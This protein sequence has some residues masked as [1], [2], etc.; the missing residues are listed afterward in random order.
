MPITWPHLKSAGSLK[1]SGSGL[2]DGTGGD[3]SLETLTVMRALTAM[4]RTAFF[5]ARRGYL[6]L[7]TYV[8]HG[9]T[10]ST[11]YF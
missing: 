5:M 3:C 11:G 8:N 6:K 7:S 4:A 10:E 2:N 1:K 9:V